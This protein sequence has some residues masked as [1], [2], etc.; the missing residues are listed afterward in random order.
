MCHSR[1]LFRDVQWARDENQFFDVD[2]CVFPIKQGN[3]DV[4]SPVLNLVDCSVKT[5]S[6]LWSECNSQQNVQEKLR[7]VMNVD[8]LGGDWT[9]VIK[10]CENNVLT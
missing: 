1:L 9:A 2:H 3:L 4:P 8:G 7:S 5:K 10:D 6:N